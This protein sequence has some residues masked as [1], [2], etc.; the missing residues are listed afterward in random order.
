MQGCTENLKKI[1]KRKFWKTLP[2]KQL[3]NI[4]NIVLA[5]KF[6]IENDFVNGS[7]IKLDGGAD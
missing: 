3:G 2:N 1:V 7:V 5:V 4:K 6:L